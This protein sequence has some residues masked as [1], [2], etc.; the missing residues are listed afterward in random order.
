ML[1]YVS[2]LT[3]YICFILLRK[4][5]KETRLKK[6]K[7]FPSFNLFVFNENDYITIN[8]EDKRIF[9]K[10]MLKFTLFNINILKILGFL[11]LIFL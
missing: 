7:T 9:N 10:K 1:T 6:Q 5:K 11:R 8:N 4:I 2:N 3:T